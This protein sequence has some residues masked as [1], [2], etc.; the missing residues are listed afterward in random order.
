MSNSVE[1]TD[2]QTRLAR[3]RDNNLA[4]LYLFNL[5]RI[6]VAAAT[7]SMEQAV[8]GMVK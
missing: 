5:A 7:G 8:K 1:L 3:A 4:A 6:D 2:A